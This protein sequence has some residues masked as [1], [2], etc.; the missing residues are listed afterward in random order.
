MLKA[1]KA[2]K[3]DKLVKKALKELCD[4]FRKDPTLY[5][6]EKHLHNEFDRILR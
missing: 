1:D 5:L 6:E 4:K 3:A 2:D